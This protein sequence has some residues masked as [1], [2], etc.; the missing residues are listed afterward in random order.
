MSSSQLVPTNSII[1][2][3]GYCTTKQMFWSQQGKQPQILVQ[4][5]E[6]Y[7]VNGD[8]AWIFLFRF[9]MDFSGHFQ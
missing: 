7:D 1:F 5:F 3:D 2:Q 9:T 6:S 4:I 8:K